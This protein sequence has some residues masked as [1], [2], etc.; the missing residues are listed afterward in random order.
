MNQHAVPDVYTAAEI[1]AAAGVSTREAALLI[2]R[3]AGFTHP[4]ALVSQPDAILVV[5]ALRQGRRS[6]VPALFAPSAPARHRTGLPVLASGGL[7]AA[8]LAIVAALSAATLASPAVSAPPEF[9]PARMV[10]LALPGPGGG[11]GGGG[12]KQAAPVARAQLKGAA[13][14]RSPVPPRRTVRSEA[15]R[16]ETPP[17]DP[18]P[19]PKP[20]EKPAPPPE[21]VPHADPSP[22]AA[23][24]VAPVAADPADRAGTPD[25]TVVTGSRGSGVGGGTGTGSGSGIGEGDGAGLGPGSGGGTGGGPYR[26]GA[27]ITPPSLLREV[28]PI[29]TEEARRR[30]VEGEVV[31]ETVVRSDGSVGSLRVVRGLDRGLDARAVE[32]VRQWRFSPA[33]RH[34]TPVDVLVEVAVEFRLR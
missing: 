3:A 10:F 12:L 11:G 7:H 21:P 29:Y 8:A 14:V 25:S 26:P 30:G 13:P 33:R 17:T 27:G 16:I 24:P 23:A 5:R 2:E 1:A 31:V 32:A 15:P 34:G 28:K 6:S 20:V 4:S 18:P 19:A 9:K 22:P